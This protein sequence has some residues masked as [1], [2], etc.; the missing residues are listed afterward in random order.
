M[1]GTETYT[2]DQL[3]AAYVK[4]VTLVRTDPAGVEP[5]EKSR[6]RPI[7]EHAGVLFDVLIGFVDRG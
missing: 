4:W 7:E 5:D 6:S 1:A 3:R 2:R